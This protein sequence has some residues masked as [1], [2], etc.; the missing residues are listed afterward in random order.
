MRWLI[1]GTFSALFFAQHAHAEAILPPDLPPGFEDIATQAMNMCGNEGHPE[2]PITGFTQPHDF[3]GDGTADYLVESSQFRC[4][5]HGELIWGGTAGTAYKIYNS[6]PDGSFKRAFEAS[7]HALQLVDMFD[8]ERAMA[9]VIFRHG[10][11]CGL[12]G[13]SSCVNAAIWDPITEAFTGMGMST[14]SE[15]PIED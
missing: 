3:N 12:S 8:D 11:Y 7:G 14:Y 1:A 15:H 4:Q 13:A 9:I 10:S 6:H 2:L 5:P